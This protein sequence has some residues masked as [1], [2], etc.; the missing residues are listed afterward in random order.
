MYH[1]LCDLSVNRDMFCSVLFCSVLYIGLLPIVS[2]SHMYFI[3]ALRVY[4]AFISQVSIS[5]LTTIYTNKQF[6]VWTIKL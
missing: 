1:L 3:T 5:M 4:I 6:T 2:I